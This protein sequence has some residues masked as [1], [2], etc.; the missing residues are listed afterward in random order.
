MRN[1]LLLA[2]MINGLFSNYL[3]GQTLTPLTNLDPK[4]L[5]VGISFAGKIIN[6]V[7]WSDKNGKNIIIV[8]ESGI[9]SNKTDDNKSGNLYASLYNFS[10][11]KAKQIWKLNDFVKDCPLDIEISFIPNTFQVT[12]LDKNG[13]AEVWLMYKTACHGD[14][15]PCDMKIIMHEGERKFA[16]RGRNKVKLSETET[17]GGEYTEDKSFKEGPKQFR[18]FALNLWKKNILQ[19]WE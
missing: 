2:L 12:D 9:I 14:V 8:S 1:Y 19:K 15:S 17:E 16:I 7:E 18:D 11:N 13:I 5:P 6:A 4:N 10:N 3:D